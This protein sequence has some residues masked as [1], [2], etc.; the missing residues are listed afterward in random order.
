MPSR[1]RI[2]AAIPAADTAVVT[3]AMTGR[4]GPWDT[5]ES[6]TRCGGYAHPGLE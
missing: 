1:T 6:G 5:P 3:A 2:P 4:R